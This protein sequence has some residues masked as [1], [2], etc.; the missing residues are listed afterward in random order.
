MNKFKNP[1]STEKHQDVSK[2]QDQ[3]NFIDIYK[4]LPI[5]PTDQIS[6]LPKPYEREIYLFETHIAG[7][8]YIKDI[9]EIVKEFSEGEIFSFFREAKNEHDNLA[10][11]IKTSKNKKIGYIPKADNQIF[12]RLMDAGKLLFGKL[13]S[14]K[15]KGS[16]HEILLEIYLKD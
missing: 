8:A 2:T 11:A 13:K 9:Q 10:I 6:N 7:T 3:Q 1:G 5:I 15:V 14:L 4:S 12:S 16:W